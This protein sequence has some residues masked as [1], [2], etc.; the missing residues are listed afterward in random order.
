VDLIYQNEDGSWGWREFPVEE[1][2]PQVYLEE[3]SSIVIA[4]INPATIKSKYPSEEAWLA[5]Q[6]QNLATDTLK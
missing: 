2:T 1:W 5:S 6:G 4:K 3:G